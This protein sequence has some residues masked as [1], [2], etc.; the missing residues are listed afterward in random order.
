MAVVAFWQLPVFREVRLEESYV[1]G[2]RE[3][4]GEIRFDMDLALGE[5]HAS[6]RAPRGGSGEQGCFRRGRIVFKT[7]SDVVW[8]EKRIPTDVD[9]DA[10]ADL[11]KIDTFVLD[12]AT[13]K[14]RGPWGRLELRAGSLDVDVW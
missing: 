10:P 6:Y 12:G 9:P 1:L 4:A 13:Y 5:R 2:V 14:L 11:G 8:Q 3:S 7:V